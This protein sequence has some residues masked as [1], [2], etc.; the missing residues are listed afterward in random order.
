M[1]M[2][3][4]VVVSGVLVLKSIAEVDEEK[5]AQEAISDPDEKTGDDGSME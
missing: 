4:I 1:I 3:E 2:R 5:I